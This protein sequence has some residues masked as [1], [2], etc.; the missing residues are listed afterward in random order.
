MMLDLF[1]EGFE[2]VEL[3]ADLELAAYAQGGAEE[4]FW[5]AFGPGAAVDVAADWQEAWKR[6]H[7]PVRIGALWVGPPWEEPDPDATAVVIDPG[8]AFGTGSHA[9]TR[10]CL[11][12]LME[13]PRSSLVD[14]GCGSGVLAIAAAR[15]GFAPVT[16]VDADLDAVS[17]AT[18]NAR[19]NRVDI[20][21]W[22]A[23]FLEDEL[24]SARL[25]V[26]N[27]TSEAVEAVSTR[28]DGIALIT[29]GYVAGDRPRLAGWTHH[30][31]REAAG[32][33]ADLFVRS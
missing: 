25:A 23:D 8:R 1:P 13:R 17:A 3:D 22:R 11:E 19:R 5:Q 4:R 7:R 26:A 14:L 10:L 20:A 27:V 18:E 31:R 2:E 24:P 32:W 21:V 29:S 15:L 12:L 33:A 30:E 16:A 6:F 28:V 9:T